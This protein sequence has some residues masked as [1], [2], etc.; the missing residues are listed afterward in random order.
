MT[1]KLSWFERGLRR[2]FLFIDGLTPGGKKLQ[3][4]LAELRRLK[5]RKAELDK[6]LEAASRRH[7]EALSEY[8]ASKAEAERLQ[9][10]Y[11]ADLARIEKVKTLSIQ[12]AL[13]GVSK[14]GYDFSES[15]PFS[16]SSDFRARVAMECAEY[17]QLEQDERARGWPV[18]SEDN[19][20]AEKAR[21]YDLAM[22]ALRQIKPPI[23]GCASAN[24]SLRECQS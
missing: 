9:K 19:Y 11:E 15:N 16:V 18:V 21:G 13:S 2:I 8:K 7:A 12:A 23:V 22:Q 6:E 5:A 24:P 20:L 10:Q 4:E 14:A 3:A 17:H 1:N